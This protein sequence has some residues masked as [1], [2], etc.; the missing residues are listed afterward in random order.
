MW[1]RRLHCSRATAADS[2][3]GG[4]CKPSCDTGRDNWLLLFCASRCPPE[5][6]LRLRGVDCGVPCML[7]RDRELGRESEWLLFRLSA[8]F[9]FATSSWYRAETKR[10]YKPAFGCVRRNRVMFRSAM[11]SLYGEVGD[12]VLADSIRYR[13]EVNRASTRSICRV[14]WPARRLDVREGAWVHEVIGR[15]SGISRGSPRRFSRSSGCKIVK[16]RGVGYGI[17]TLEEADRPSVMVG[18]LPLSYSPSP[19]S[20]EGPFSARKKGLSATIAERLSPIA[21]DGPEQRLREETENG[22]KVPTRVQNPEL[23]EGKQI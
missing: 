17:V 16:F 23:K 20:V 14:P 19:E 4:R 9:L 21:D 12:I 13:C 22:L 18:Q 11:S 5:L 8:M 6:R 10:E 3:T 7:G 15:D 2:S 1:L